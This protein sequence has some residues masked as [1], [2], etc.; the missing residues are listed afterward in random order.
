M[1]AASFLLLSLGAVI[2]IGRE[3]L[4]GHAGV[5]RIVP[6]TAET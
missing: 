3:R 1:L 2:A 4:R 5:A 6:L